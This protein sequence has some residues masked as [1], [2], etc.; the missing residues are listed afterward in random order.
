M[1][2][3]ALDASLV[4]YCNIADIMWIEVRGKLLT[5]YNVMTAVPVEIIRRPEVKRLIDASDAISLSHQMES[6]TSRASIELTLLNAISGN[7][8][9]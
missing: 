3:A 9:A 8:R 7:A 5:V 2:L 6:S 1:T 4:H